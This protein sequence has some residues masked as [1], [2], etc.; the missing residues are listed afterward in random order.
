MNAQTNDTILNRKL[1]CT[2]TND[3]IQSQFY[4]CD[5]FLFGWYVIFLYAAKFTY[6]FNIQ[7]VWDVSFHFTL[8]E[9]SIVGLES[10]DLFDFIKFCGIRICFCLFVTSD[11][12]RLDGIEWHLSLDII[13]GVAFGRICLTGKFII[14]NCGITK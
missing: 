4:S 11:S 3:L 12:A 14:Y 8:Y 9:C 5:V 2:F 6:N 7:P 1:S 13:S 10:Y